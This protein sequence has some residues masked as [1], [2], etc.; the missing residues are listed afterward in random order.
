MLS[1]KI[2]YL[3]GILLLLLSSLPLRAE[4][5]RVLNGDFDRNGVINQSDVTTLASMCVARSL[6]QKGEIGQGAILIQPV[7]Q[8]TPSA[9]SFLMGD[10]NGDGRLTL[11]DVT[12]LIALI[13]HAEQYRYAVIREG[14]I[15]MGYYVGQ[16]FIT[17]GEDEFIEDEEEEF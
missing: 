2:K 12:T 13:G 9:T 5:V 10:M 6:L 1:A 4:E 7:S 8:F 3:L 11:T 15:V 16:M 14:K 17:L